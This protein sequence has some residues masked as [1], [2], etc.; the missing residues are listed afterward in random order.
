MPA[1]YKKETAIGYYAPGRKKHT[2]M[3]F[4]E[5]FTKIQAQKRI[6][7][8]LNRLKSRKSEQFAGNTSKIKGNFVAT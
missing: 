5:I 2:V 3:N 4:C 8:V 1:A 6:S 7:A